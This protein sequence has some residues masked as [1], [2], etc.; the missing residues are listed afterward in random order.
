MLPR[1]SYLYSSLP[2]S[3]P[4]MG[5]EVFSIRLPLTPYVVTSTNCSGPSTARP[6]FSSIFAVSVLIRRTEPSSPSCSL[7]LSRTVIAGLRETLAS[8]ACEG[9]AKVKTAVHNI[10]AGRSRRTVQF[11]STPPVSNSVGGRDS[12]GPSPYVVQTVRKNTI[13]GRE[14]LRNC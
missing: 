8:C 10:R 13:T 5:Y 1:S 14:L 2:T 7:V 12:G 3:P 4:L 6:S 11:I 9:A